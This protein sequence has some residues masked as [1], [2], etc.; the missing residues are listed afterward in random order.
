MG[1]VAWRL[2]CGGVNFEKPRLPTP[3]PL[4]AKHYIKTLK[5]ELQTPKAVTKISWAN[6][7]LV[8]QRC[9]ARLPIDS[10]GHLRRYITADRSFVQLGWVALGFGAGFRL[11]LLNGMLCVLVIG[12]TLKPQTHKSLQLDLRAWAPSALRT[13]RP[14]QHARPF[15]RVL[16]QLQNFEHNPSTPKP[17]P[18][19]SNHNTA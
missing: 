3:N 9:R 10:L 7:C 13:A 8:P 2:Q 14:R 12:Y 17:S 16:Q 19:S 5:L 4:N 11:Y 6:W 15:P 1:L 18:A